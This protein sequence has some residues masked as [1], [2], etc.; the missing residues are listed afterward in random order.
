MGAARERMGLMGAS[1]YTARSVPPSPPSLPYHVYTPPSSP[2]LPYAVS[3]ILPSAPPPP[4]LPHPTMRVSSKRRQ[5][6]HQAASGQDF[7]CKMERKTSSP[8]ISPSPPPLTGWVGSA[9][10]MRES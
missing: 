1:S 5:G 8:C 7:I 6:Y 10:I 2:S 9:Q 3:P 4:P